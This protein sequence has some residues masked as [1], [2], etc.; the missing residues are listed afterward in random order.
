MAETESENPAIPIMKKPNL[1]V[2]DRP[3]WSRYFSRIIDVVWESTVLG[4]AYS[5]L[6][7]FIAPGFQTREAQSDIIY[8]IFVLPLSLVFDA[9]IYQIFK[10]TPGKALNGIR[11]TTVTG[12]RLIFR[13]YLA[14][15]SGVWV[16][17]LGFGIP[18]IFIGTAVI[19]YRRLAAGKSATYDAD[20]GYRVVR[21]KPG[22]VKTTGFILFYIITAGCAGAVKEAENYFIYNQPSRTSSNVAEESSYI[23]TNPVTNL[24]I[25]VD[26]FW[27]P[28]KT[29]NAQKEDLYEF[30]DRANN[31]VIVL[32]ASEV[33]PKTS[34]SDYLN[35][36]RSATN[37]PFSDS[38]A[39]SQIN[40]MPAWTGNGIMPGSTPLNFDVTIIQDGSNFWR[41]VTV[42]DP[43]FTDSSGELT[44]L[45]Q[46]LFTTV[47]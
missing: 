35:A 8:Y 34:L 38:G 14:R 33:E 18:L 5:I 13:Q 21:S 46:A 12:E 4:T 40:G 2:D 27:S 43:T 6:M 41:E 36:F 29:Q 44:K 47:D 30:T 28:S 25:N 24:S 26:T 17:G 32:F 1:L 22:A 10:N 19:Q 3:T 9:V 31:K 20:N 45:R 15:N 37:M 11:V 16:M 23:W 39:F 42:S 7:L